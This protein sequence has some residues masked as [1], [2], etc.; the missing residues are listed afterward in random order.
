MFERTSWNVLLLFTAIKS[1]IDLLWCT[2]CETVHSQRQRHFNKYILFVFRTGKATRHCISPSVSRQCLGNVSWTS[3]STV[4]GLRCRT[5]R[6]SG[7]QTSAPPTCWQDFSNTCSPTVGRPWETSLQP[8]P[9]PVR[10][11]VL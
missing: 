2:I 9:T 8:P 3:W 6:P 11:S 10:L 4:R 7:L 1:C 5:Q